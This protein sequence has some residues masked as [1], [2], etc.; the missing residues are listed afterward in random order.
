[1]ESFQSNE[2]PTLQS[3]G[4]MT[5]PV[6]DLVAEVLDLPAMDR[7]R[8][9][10]LLIRSFESTSN[11]QKAW[12]DLASQRREGVRQGAVSMALGEGALQRVRARIA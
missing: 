3:G 11:A 8:L 9:L 10:E 6:D 12:M 1:M 5:T 7:A 4:Y 2:T